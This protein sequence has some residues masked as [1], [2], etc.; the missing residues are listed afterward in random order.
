MGIVLKKLCYLLTCHIW[1]ARK[2]AQFTTSHITF[3]S[4]TTQ[5]SVLLWTHGCAWMVMTMNVLMTRVVTQ[6]KSVVMM[7][8]RRT[9]SDLYQYQGVALPDRL[10]HVSSIVCA[11]NTRL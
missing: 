6:M 11:V 8:A 4:Q 10:Y 2:S 7:A 9:V 5:A 1:F 3:S